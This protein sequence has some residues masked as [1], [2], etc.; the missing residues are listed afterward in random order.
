MSRTIKKN[1]GQ[2]IRLARQRSGLTQEALAARISRTPESISNIERGLQQPGIATVQSLAK[3]LGLPL[4]ELVGPTEEPRLS[5]ERLRMEFQLR[6][7]ARRLND[8]DLAIIVGQV[9]M[10]LALK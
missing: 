2:K 10:L 6:D 7:L 3:V 8:R 5:P 4:S 1:L 9:Q